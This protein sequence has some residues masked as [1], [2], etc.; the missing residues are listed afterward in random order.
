MSMYADISKPPAPLPQPKPQPVAEGITLLPPLSRLGH[1]PGLVILHPD[2][3]KHLDIIEGVPSALIKWAEEGYAVVEIQ[4]RALQNNAGE[5]LG[6][7]LRHLRG[8]DGF[9]KD[10]KIGLVGKS[11]SMEIL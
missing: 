2:S 11:S 1:G 6:L 5:T 8:C 9:V 4:A 10:S 3:D 7:A